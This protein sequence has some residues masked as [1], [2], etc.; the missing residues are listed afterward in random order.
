MSNVENTLNERGKRYGDFADHAAIVE[1]LISV[2][3]G[4]SPH[5]Q[6]VPTVAE[7][8]TVLV[9]ITSFDKLD[10]VKKQAIRAICG[11]MAR[12][13]SPDGDPEHRD[14]W[15][16]IQGY[17]KLAEDR[18]KDGDA[19]KQTELDLADV[20]V[21]GFHIA[22][23]PV[24]YEY[25]ASHNCDYPAGSYCMACGDTLA[26]QR[27]LDPSFVWPGLPRYDGN[28]GPATPSELDPEDGA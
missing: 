3:S 12:I 8:G 9:P 27:E 1:A 13:L 24:H 21:R 22:P 23:T 15:H 18:C 19:D 28:K 14:H 20:H 17:A 26:A 25:C 7:P 16:D 2:V 11:K 6:T 4:L 5:V 10:P